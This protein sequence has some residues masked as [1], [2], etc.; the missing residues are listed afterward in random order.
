MIS[1]DF[2]LMIRQNYRIGINTFYCCADDILKDRFN[3]CPVV[4][5]T[6]KIKV[7]TKKMI[8]NTIKQSF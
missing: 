5:V 3:I 2:T 8:S 6:L 1:L 7:R 4:I